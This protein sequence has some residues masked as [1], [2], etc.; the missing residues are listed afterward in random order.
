MGERA[1]KEARR[2]EGRLKG[3]GVER[4]LSWP[5]SLKSVTSSRV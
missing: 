3:G 4:I 5:Q 2:D 1:A